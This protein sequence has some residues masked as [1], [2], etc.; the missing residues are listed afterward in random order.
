M[1]EPYNPLAKTNLADSIEREILKMPLVPLK[2]LQR[3]EGAGVYALYY[4]GTFEIYGPPRDSLASEDACPIY[5]GKA[6]PEGG[7]IGG[8]RGPATGPTY[9][10]FNR[11]KK[12]A[13][14]LISLTTLPRPTLEF[15]I[16]SSMMC[17]FHLVRMR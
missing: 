10:L 6:I 4:A 14:K 7:R 12:H 3:F 15:D 2:D 13:G 1:T 11:L 16:S 17:G 9:A 8:L 5:V